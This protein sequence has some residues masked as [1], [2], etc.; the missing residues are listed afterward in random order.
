MILGTLGLAYVALNVA[1]L[2]LAGWIAPRFSVDGPWTSVG[3]T[4]VVWL[5]NVCLRAARPGR[6][7]GEPAPRPLGRARPA[8]QEAVLWRPRGVAQPG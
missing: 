7:R 4:I 8:L 1:M 3:A 2:A 5:L 6:R